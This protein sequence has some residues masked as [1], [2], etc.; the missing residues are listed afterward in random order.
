MP[1]VAASPVT[2]DVAGIPVP[3]GSMVAVNGRVIHRRTPAL[4][5][6]RHAINDEARRAFDGRAPLA[7]PVLVTLEFRYARPK[8]ARKSAWYVDKRPDLDKV[9]RA[10]LDALTGVAFVDDAQVASLSLS[11][12]YTCDDEA[13]GVFVVVGRLNR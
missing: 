13:P 7:G 5:A 10:A 9:A 8:S 3:Q 12:R 1:P 4:Q 11:K 6:W 2:F